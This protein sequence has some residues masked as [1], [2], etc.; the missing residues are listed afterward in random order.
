MSRDDKKRTA[1]FDIETGEIQTTKIR[2]SEVEIYYGFG[3]KHFLEMSGDGKFMTM[4]NRH[5]GL[6]DRN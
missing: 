6:T 3:E 1:K 5:V 4:W 2:K